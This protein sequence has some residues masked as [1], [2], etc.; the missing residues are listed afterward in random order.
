[1][2]TDGPRIAASSLATHN[3]L[4]TKQLHTEA[5]VR[6]FSKERLKACGRAKGCHMPNS[7]SFQTDRQISSVVQ[8]L[9]APAN[10]EDDCKNDRLPEL[11]GDEDSTIRCLKIDASMG[12]EESSAAASSTGVQQAPMRKAADTIC[13]SSG[14][15]DTAGTSTCS[16]FGNDDLEATAQ[17][18]EASLGCQHSPAEYEEQ[19][20]MKD[21]CLHQ[22]RLNI[23]EVCWQ[24]TTSL[25][26]IS[27]D[28]SGVILSSPTH[29]S[30]TSSPD[31]RAGNCKDSCQQL[32]ETDLQKAQSQNEKE[33]A[34][35]SCR[36]LP[37]SH[38]NAGSCDSNQQ[39]CN[40]RNQNIAR[41]L[42]APQGISNPMVRPSTLPVSSS[43]ASLCVQQASSILLARQ[44]HPSAQSCQLPSSSPVKTSRPFDPFPVKHVNT[45]RAKTGLKLGLYTP[46]MLEQI[47]GQML[48][49]LQVRKSRNA[50]S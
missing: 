15:E 45:N 27:E 24:E 46:S 8:D 13:P 14:S 5:T 26:Q 48:G 22:D 12:R 32:S 2:V 35:L 3:S 44:Y 7:S 30:A 16:M 34:N 20:E 23:T 6:T 1:M 38:V 41:S 25:Q 36:A 39:D 33:D 9:A 4:P 43:T 31:K 49:G 40:Y 19:I 11:V 47:Q 21:S 29:G 18:P 10:T 28:D 37:D 50:S 17:H 42:S